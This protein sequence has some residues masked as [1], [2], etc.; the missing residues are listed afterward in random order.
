MGERFLL[1]IVVIVVVVVDDDDG[2]SC[3]GVREWECLCLC[4]DG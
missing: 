1:T 3:Y 2:L 4:C